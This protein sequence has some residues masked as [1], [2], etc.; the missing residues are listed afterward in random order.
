[1]RL[2]LQARNL[3][4]DQKAEA[5]GDGMR[6]LLESITDGFF[7][8]DQDERFTY[9]NPRAAQLLMRTRE[10]LIGKKAVLIL[11]RFTPDRKAILDGLRE[12]LRSHDYVPILFDFEK[13]AR[14]SVP[15]SPCAANPDMTR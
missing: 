5:L 3:L 7:A 11:G 10:Q 12:A 13:P 14:T 2:G 15:G 6:N 9:L 1:M 8:L 4:V